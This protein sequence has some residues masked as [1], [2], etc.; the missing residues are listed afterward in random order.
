MNTTNQ[1][2]TPGYLLRCRRGENVPDL[3]LAYNSE[4]NEKQKN[5]FFVLKP[6]ADMSIKRKQIERINEY[7]VTSIVAKEIEMLG[8]IN[9]AHQL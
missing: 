6:G 9:D 2:S 5:F 4:R 1:G 8:K 7:K 3:V